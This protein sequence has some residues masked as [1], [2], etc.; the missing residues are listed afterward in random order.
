MSPLTLE[1]VT[2]INVHGIVLNAEKH[3]G[4]PAIPRERTRQQH[5]QNLRRGFGD[6]ARDEVTGEQGHV[7]DERSCFWMCDGSGYLAVQTIRG[8]PSER[9]GKGNGK[10]KGRYKRTRRAFFGDE[11]LQDPGWCS[12]E[13]LN[14]LVVQ[15]R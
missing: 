8:P 13:D 5:E 4:K 14:S 15:K 10:S 6:W 1:S 9:N 11:Q 3:D 7:D 12:E 2:T